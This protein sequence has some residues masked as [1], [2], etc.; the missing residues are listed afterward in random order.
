[1][2]E[3]EKNPLDALAAQPGDIEDSLDLGDIDVGEA[4]RRLTEFIDQSE[5][6]Q[7]RRFAI[8]FAPA[9]GDG[10]LTL[11]QPVGRLLLEMRKAGRITRCLP[12]PD[13]TGFYIEFPEADS[14]KP[15]TN[16]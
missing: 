3:F 8:R 1:M 11:F 14:P 4:T 9:R 2:P 10:K 7:A 12:L 5:D 15:N 16:D 6:R 13:G